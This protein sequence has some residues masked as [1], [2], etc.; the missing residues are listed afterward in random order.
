MLFCL[1]CT[2]PGSKMKTIKLGRI[3]SNPVREEISLE[4]MNGSVEMIP[5]ETSDSCLLSKLEQLVVEDFLWVV[6]DKQLYKFTLDGKFIQ[7]IGEIGQGPEEYINPSQ[8]LVDPQTKRLFVLDY[9]GRKTLIFDYDGN[10]LKSIKLPQDYSLSKIALDKGNLLYTSNYNSVIPDLFIG[11][12]DN[13]QM[14]TLSFRDRTMGVEGFIGETFIYTIDNETF[15][16]HYFNDTVYVCINNQLKPAYLFDLGDYIYRFE[17]LEMNPDFTMKVP[18]EG[19]R[20][21]VTNFIETP[22]YIFVNYLVAN[23]SNKTS[24][25][26]VRLAIYDKNSATMHADAQLICSQIPAV[27][28]KKFDPLIPSTDRKS[29]YTYKLAEDLVEENLIEGLN[30]E[31]NPVL[32]KYSF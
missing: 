10:V 14:D 25:P 31:D 9:F 21:Q 7:K 12:L 29:I 17:E 11:D 26:D 3:M 20:T 18:I 22:D 1:S 5:L 16:Y 6:A 24:G 19:L 13:G 4:S 15:L 32:V 8:I 30:A 27:S 2:E 23:P 28:L